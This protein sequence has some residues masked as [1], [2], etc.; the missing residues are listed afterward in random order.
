MGENGYTLAD[1]ANVVKG[2]DGDS[3]IL[4][5]LFFLIFGMNGFGKNGQTSGDSDI[6][7]AMDLNSIQQGQAGIAADIQRG[8]YEINGTTQHVAYDNLSEIRDVQAAVATNG[9]NII[10]ALTAMQANMQNCCCETQRSIDAVNY[11]LASQSAAI[12]AND[13]ANTQKVLDAISA[14]RMAE[15][16]GKISELQL[17]NAMCGVVRYPQ[18]WTYSAGASP[19]CQCGGCATV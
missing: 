5:L 10:N 12:Q 2:S 18:A 3:L 4:I 8:I 15:L 9:S 17:Q 6:Q 19:F 7:R 14:N 13:T 11:N 1:I 16:E